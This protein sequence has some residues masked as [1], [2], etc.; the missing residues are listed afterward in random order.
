MEQQLEQQPKKRGGAR[1]GSGRKTKY[2]STVVIRVPEAYRPAIQALI[3]HLDATRMINRH[4]LPSTSEPLFMRSLDG[5][6]Q[7][8]TFT[9]APL[10]PREIQQVIALDKPVEEP[11]EEPVTGTAQAKRKRKRHRDDPPVSIDE[12]ESV[13]GWHVEYRAPRQRAW[14]RVDGLP[15]IC[16]ENAEE[17]VARQVVEGSLF[18]Y[19]V[20]PVV[21]N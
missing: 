18:K 7:H 10:V 17:F 11:V 9:T 3:E 14:R 21:G 13:V 20:V 2:P 6:A 15:W 19:R 16:R 8:V 1:P 12:N 4:Y 5:K